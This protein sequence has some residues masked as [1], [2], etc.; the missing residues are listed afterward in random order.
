MKDLLRSFFVVGSMAIFSQPAFSQ[1]A[2]QLD[3]D[4]HVRIEKPA[5]LDASDAQAVYR[6][7]S[8]L[9]AEGY[10]LHEDP[11]AKN[12]QNWTKQNTTP[13][14]SAGHGNRY[15]NNYGNE[16]SASYLD[17]E[18]GE[19]MP[20]GAILAK[21]SFTVTEER[22]I[23]AGA[24]FVMEKLG[25]GSHP[26]TGDW[27]YLMVLPDGSKIGDTTG[28]DPQAMAFCHDCHQQVEAR[29]YVFGVPAKFEK[30]AE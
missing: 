27:R 1:S 29:D 23:F 15:L 16:K 21:D 20:V 24:L 13:Y 10:A 11:T 25:A 30:V 9:M 19:F 26:E 4:G 18:E 8:R 12:Y 2:D 14:L 28:S 5:D 6:E 3:L 22:E 17:L 7:I